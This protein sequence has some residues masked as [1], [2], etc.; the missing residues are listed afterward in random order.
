MDGDSAK[1]KCN[2]FQHVAGNEKNIR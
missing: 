1:R 2:Y